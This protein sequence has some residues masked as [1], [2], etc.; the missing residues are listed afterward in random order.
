MALCACAVAIGGGAWWYTGGKNQ[1]PHTRLLVEPIAVP[2]LSHTGVDLSLKKP[3]ER[4]QPVLFYPNGRKNMAI[5]DTI[6]NKV[7]YV[8]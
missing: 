5:R 8:P 7:R 3:K 6:H 1:E 2:N 4:K